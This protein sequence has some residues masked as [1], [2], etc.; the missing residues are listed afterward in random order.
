ME[1]F[2]HLALNASKLRR[3]YCWSIYCLGHEVMKISLGVNFEKIQ[4]GAFY[5]LTY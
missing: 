5:P 3:F 4:L 2:F 1:Y